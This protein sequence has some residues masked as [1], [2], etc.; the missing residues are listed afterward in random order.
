MSK[1]TH[2]SHIY[3]HI[4]LQ[5]NIRYVNLLHVEHILLPKLHVK[6]RQVCL[7]VDI[8]PTENWYFA[9]IFIFRF[10]NRSLW[11]VL[12]V[13]EEFFGL[14]WSQRGKVFGLINHSIL[15]IIEMRV[16]RKFNNIFIHHQ[17]E[18]KSKTSSSKCYFRNC[19]SCQI[20]TSIN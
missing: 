20:V 18:N 14:V 2:F 13:R 11:A 16:V 7:C 3:I 1:F 19:S 10:R 12:K 9:K 5:K 17:N 4:D 15:K 6:V 8:L